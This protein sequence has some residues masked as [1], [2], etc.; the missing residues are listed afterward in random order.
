[1]RIAATALILLSLAC[2]SRHVEA[3]QSFHQIRIIP[4]STGTTIGSIGFREL[5]SSGTDHLFLQGPQVIG[6]PRIVSLKDAANDYELAGEEIENVFT[7]RQV[8]VRFNLLEEFIRLER[9]SD[10]GH[11]LAVLDSI[12]S[13]F[14]IF[15]NKGISIASTDL[16]LNRSGTPISMFS[17]DTSGAGRL[18]IG[19]TAFLST[20]HDAR[21]QIAIESNVPALSIKGN[22][23]YGVDYLRV[24]NES[25]SINTRVGSDSFL[26]T[27]GLRPSDPAQVDIGNT[28][29]GRFRWLFGETLELYNSGS[30]LSRHILDIKGAS[31][32]SGDYMRMRNWSDIMVQQVQND[33]LW[34]TSGIRAISGVSPNIG[35]PTPGS[36]M[37]SIFVSA[38]D[39]NSYI[40]LTTSGASTSPAGTIR[41]AY[42]GSQ[43]TYSASGSGYQPFGDVTIATPQTISGAK[44]FAG[45]ITTTSI[46]G[47]GG[48]MG[49]ST[50]STR[51][52]QVYSENFAA[53][54]SITLSGSANMN[55]SASSSI[56]A[57]GF[58]GATFNLT[59]PAGQAITAIRAE[60]GIVVSASCGT[61]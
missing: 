45:G 30:D 29:S 52:G 11:Y 43:L 31:G 57:H 7:A 40:Q 27:T 20:A 32:Q 51:W 10:P 13:Y 14:T 17:D 49:G 16:K 54:S 58:P 9:S 6:A 18:K 50:L 5:Q 44:T 61:P 36:R 47:P 4:N 21:V 22:S 15:S 35:S 38:I 59:C 8:F 33:G 2:S 34:Y 60:I 42:N 19:S 55:F 3:Q 53:F 26:Y 23:S 25:G 56:T 46:T 48:V 28:S 41:L 39:S 1:M 24:A 37:G 12:D